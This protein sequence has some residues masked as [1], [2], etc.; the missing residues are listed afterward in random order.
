[1]DRMHIANTPS[2]VES[3]W[4]PFPGGE[5]EGERPRALC[6][7]CRA[8]SASAGRRTSGTQASARPALCFQCYRVGLERVRQL[9]A[10]ATLNTASEA[11]FQSQLPFEPVNVSRLAQLKA[12][13][14]A[15]RAASRTGSGQFVE[16]R[17][18][19][20]IEARHALAMIVSGLRQ[21]QQSAGGPSAD[22][23]AQVHAITRA[24]ELQLPE[25]WLPFVV[26]R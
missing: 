18:R 3:D 20:Q 19:A 2:P 22:Y 1:M 26:A 13:R 16:K 12:D 4:M 10:A 25:A 14:Q 9:K 17:R 15:A 21:R 23:A 8:K 5:L 11:R 7:D 24:A 6:P